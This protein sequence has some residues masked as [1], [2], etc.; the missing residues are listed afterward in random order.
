MYKIPRS[1][2]C[3]GYWLSF[4]ITARVMASMSSWARVPPG[5]TLTAGASGF[6]LDWARVPPG[7]AA[8]GGEI[9]RASCRERV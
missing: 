5:G 9:G 3:R 4:A 8:L 1:P 2:L 7:A 6:R